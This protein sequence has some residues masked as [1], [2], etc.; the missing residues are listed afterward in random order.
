MHAVGTAG[1][2]LGTWHEASSWSWAPYVARR[3]LTVDNGS[4]APTEISELGPVQVTLMTATPYMIRRTLTLIRQ[5][6][7]EPYEPGVAGRVAHEDQAL[8]EAGDL[9]LYDTARPYWSVMATDLPTCQ[10][11][12]LRF[13]RG[14]L[15]L[16]QRELRHSTAVRI[17]ASRGLGAVSSQFLLQLARRADELGPA[18]AA[19]LSTLALDVVAAAFA[20]ALEAAPAETRHGALVGRLHTYIQERLGDPKLTPGSI[21]AAHHISVRY[22]H[23]L[24][25]EEGHTVA[26]WIRERRLE[27]CRHELADPLL[28]AHPISAIATRWGFVNAAHFSQAFRGA[29]GL[30]PSQFREHYAAVHGD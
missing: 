29:Y 15:P 14:L 12:V 11:L 7:P 18:E 22:L 17:P 20:Q 27:R 25:R 21:A 6:D 3:V 28:A 9:V 30:S 10:L 2:R 5:A 19:R 4:R 13:P 23:K 16:P 24:F 1:E 8:G 26:G